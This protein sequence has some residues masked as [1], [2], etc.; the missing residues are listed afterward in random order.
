M[1]RLAIDG[2]S[3]VRTR[4]MPSRRAMG[5][6]ERAAVAE[7]LDH[8]RDEDPGYQGPFEQA[9]CRAFEAFQGGGHADAVATGT[10]AVLVALAAL[11]L[12]EGADVLV[13]PVTDPG[14][15]A[16]VLFNRLRPR[17][18]DTAPDDFNTDLPRIAERLRPDT[19]A[20]V[21]VHASG[22][23]IPTIAAIAALCAERGIALVEDC[24]QA[25]GAT[26]A[27]TRVG[28]FGT[29]AAFSTMYRKSHM[30]GGAGGVVFTRSLDLHRMALACADRGKTPWLAGTDDRD[31]TNLLFPA[32]N[33]HTDEIS[34]AIGRASLGRL[35]ET[36]AARLRWV[37]RVEAGLAAAG[38]ACR[39]M[40][41]AD[42]DSPF[43]VPVLAPTTDAAAKIRFAEAV[44]AEGIPLSPHYKLVASDWPWLA[45][46]L[47]DAFGADNARAARDR[48]FCLYVNERYGDEEADDA[49]EAILKVE[50][51]TSSA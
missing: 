34:C 20:V 9:Y 38:S 12:P 8:Y 30:T 32:L 49:V 24:S 28:N 23:A 37:R 26:V 6:A 39:P 27:G 35:E 7:V 33:L 43:L 2:G 17:L 13:S 25:H 42:G 41:F 3:P 46:H 40:P 15:F 29:I 1:I 4:P 10:T 47:G 14:T 19:R 50:K 21:L 22:R 5:D 18:L 36:M 48:A 31:P 16:G 45:P 11:R 44:R 51:F